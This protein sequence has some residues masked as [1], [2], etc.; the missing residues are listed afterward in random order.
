M[1]S[2]KKRSAVDSFTHTI[3]S[4]SVFKFILC[5]LTSLSPVNVYL[6]NHSKGKVYKT[7]TTLLLN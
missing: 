6:Y 4:P 5:R 1:M 7:I 3:K 2:Q